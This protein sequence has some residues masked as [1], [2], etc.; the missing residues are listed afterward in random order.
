MHYQTKGQLKTR[1]MIFLSNF[2]PDFEDLGKAFEKARKVVDKEG[3]P[4]FYVRCLV[5][6]EDF[7]NE[8]SLYPVC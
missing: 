4:R 8:V 6:L 1:S 7:V 2:P 3:I 5:E